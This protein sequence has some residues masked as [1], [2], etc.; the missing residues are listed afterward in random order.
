MT[1][2]TPTQLRALADKAVRHDL[3]DL[4]PAE[5]IDACRIMARAWLVALLHEAGPE[6]AAMSAYAFGDEMVGGVK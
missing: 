5:R 6:F 4:D 1:K 2:P 3:Q